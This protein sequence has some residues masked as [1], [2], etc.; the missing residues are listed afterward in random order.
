MV[1]WAE[2]PNRFGGGVYELTPAGDGTWI[3]SFYAMTGGSIGAYPKEGLLMDTSGNLNGTASVGGSGNCGLVFEL[4]PPPV[5]NGIWNE[6][7]LY[8]FACGADGSTPY[9]SLI[10]DAQGSLYGTTVYGVNGVG[11]TRFLAW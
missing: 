9:S 8:N 2:N 3:E 10:S 7:V 11:L 6:N 1:P 4:T 5:G